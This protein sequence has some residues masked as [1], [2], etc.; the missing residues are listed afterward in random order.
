[1]PNRR[2]PD[3]KQ[4]S[5]PA[6]P[7]T[8]PLD[9]KLATKPPIAAVK[10]STKP[11]AA[12]PLPAVTA[13]PTAAAAKPTKRRTTARKKH[14]KTGA[15]GATGVSADERRGMIAKAAYLRGES[16]GFP[17]GGEAEDWLAAEQE[18]DALLSGGSGAA[19]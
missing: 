14:A 5:R 1:M 17:P 8:A 11:V 2:I 19:Q 16:R 10:K 12:E 3:S 6:L 18:I 15:H 4:P 9:A 13:A 7:A